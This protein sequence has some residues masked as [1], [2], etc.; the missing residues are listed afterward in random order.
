MKLV[1]TIIYF[2]N[3]FLIKSLLNTTFW[4]SLYEEKSDFFNFRIIR[5]LVYCY[6]IEIEIG[7][8]RRTKSDFRIR[9]IR[10]IRYSKRFS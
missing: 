8:N 6:N 7:F 2:K 10:L 4:E 3:R 5:L 1:K 9:Q